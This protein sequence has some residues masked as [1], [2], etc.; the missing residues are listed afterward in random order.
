MKYEIAIVVGRFQPYHNT[1]HKL[2]QHALTLGKKVLILLGSASKSADIKN[3]FTAREREAMI[4]GCFGEETQSRL[5]FKGIRDYPYKENVWITQIQNIVKNEQE[6]M[7]TLPEGRSAEHNILLG[8]ITTCLVGFFKDESS[9]YLKSF[10]QWKFEEFNGNTREGKM[11]N[12]TDIR[13]LYLEFSN[14][15]DKKV[16]RWIEI[17]ELVPLE[18]SKFLSDFYDTAKYRDLVKEYNYTQ[19]YKEDT[20]YKKAAFKPIFVTTDTLVTARGHVL[21]V[22]RGHNPGIGK[23]ALPGG[24]LEQDLTV[25]ANAIKELGEE[26]N[27]RVP[28]IILESSIKNQYVFDHPNRSLRGRTITHAFHIELNPKMEDGLPNVKGG[29]DATEAL[30]MSISEVMESEDKFFEDHHHIIRYFLGLD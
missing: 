22:K 3:P 23:L 2:V 20:Q 21:L 18:V 29:D 11:I 5:V 17:E 14:R 13:A 28:N 19:K 26:T 30:W 9:Y 4:R 1:H 16:K 7:I 6:K 15:T 24:F 12:A 8:K 25:K 10:P 27:I